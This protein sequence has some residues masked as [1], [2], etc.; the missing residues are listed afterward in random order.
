ML[1]EL[2]TAGPPGVLVITDS[3]FI[4]GRKLLHSLIVSSVQRGE[5]VHIFSFEF[6]A[7]EFLAGVPDD[8]L[9]SFSFHDGF[10]DPL[11]WRNH[12]QSLTLHD[13][14]ARTIRKRVSSSSTPVTIV[15]DSLSWIL[16]RCPLPSVCHTLRELCRPQMK[17]GSHDMR[18]LTLLHADL[19]DP[20]VVGS[21][22]T[23][24]DS[25]ID[26]TDG[27]EQLGVTIT[28][29]K[30]SGKV[31]TGKEIFRVCEDFS[32]E[33]TTAMESE[34]QSRTEVDPT[35]NLTFNLRLSETER[36]RKESA[37]LPYT[38]SENK[39]SS[40]LQS[41]GTS[42]KIFYDPDPGDDLDEE[43]PDDDLDV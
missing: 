32:L 26:V 28:Q 13:F 36:E 23:L 41:S 21:V 18:V 22:C 30:R 34:P 16:A 1:Q 10:S 35:V 38:F 19:H 17:E 8:I 7:E 4:S 11:H 2:K 42:G 31:V 27:G 29:R 5:H 24:C 6:P 43:D 25:V 14:T 40:L 9:S 39:K 33:R 37:A 20:G 15:L 3:A 12:S